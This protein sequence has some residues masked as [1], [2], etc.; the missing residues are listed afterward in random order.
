ML[1]ITSVNIGATTYIDDK[2]V[3]YYTATCPDNKMEAGTYRI[4]KS[5][6]DRAVYDSNKATCDDEATQFEKKVA[7]YARQATEL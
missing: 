2:P 4:T 6:V 7:E 5:V 3:V 1:K